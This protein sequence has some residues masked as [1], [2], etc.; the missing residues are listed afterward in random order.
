MLHVLGRGLAA[1]AILLLTTAMLVITAQASAPPPLVQS[2]LAT[3]QPRIQPVVPLLSSS[4][5]PSPS[6][7]PPPTAAPTP[8]DAP[9]AAPGAAVV[10]FQVSP[11]HIDAGERAL[12]GSSFALWL[13]AAGLL[14]VGG[15][16][17]LVITRR[18]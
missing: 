7:S 16:V 9:T 12:P 2:P 10:P 11:L 3:P 14:L 15:S 5:T 1:I 8:A 13:G 17:V 18:R 6:P 4:P